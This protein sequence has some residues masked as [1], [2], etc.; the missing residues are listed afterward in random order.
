MLR[1]IVIKAS[2]YIC[3]FRCLHYIDVW[4]QGASLVAAISLQRK[5]S[6]S[7]PKHFYHFIF[8]LKYLGSALL[9]FWY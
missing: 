8:I 5:H 9:T 1:I 2:C 4:G 6:I 3:T 7:F